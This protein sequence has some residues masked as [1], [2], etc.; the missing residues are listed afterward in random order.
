MRDVQFEMTKHRLGMTTVTGGDGRL[1]G[2]ISDGDL[3]RQ[4][5]RHGYT[6]L[7]RAAGDCMTADPATV[8]PRQLAAAALTLMEERKITSLPVVDGDGRL[9]GVVHLHDLWESQP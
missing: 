9:A 8:G 3:R 7:D 2:M 1:V 6:L 5:E 4:M